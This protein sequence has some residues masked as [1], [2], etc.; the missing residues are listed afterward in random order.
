[1]EELGRYVSMVFHMFV[2]LGFALSLSFLF[3]QKSHACGLAG[4][5]KKS[6]VFLLFFVRGNKIMSI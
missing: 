5:H 1:M 2:P 3:S 4:S 6:H